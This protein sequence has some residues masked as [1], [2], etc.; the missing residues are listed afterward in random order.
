MLY[1]YQIGPS[2]DRTH[3]RY[4]IVFWHLDGQLTANEPKAIGFVGSR[5]PEELSLNGREL[6][7]KGLLWAGGDPL[8]CPSERYSERY[9]LRGRR[10]LR[11]E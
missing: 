8:C 3:T 9:L 4:L 11:R 10:L 7:I 2:R 5:L 6:L 1:E